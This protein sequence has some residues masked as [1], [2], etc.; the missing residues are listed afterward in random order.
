MSGNID[1]TGSIWGLCLVLIAMC[2]SVYWAIGSIVYW[3]STESNYCTGLWYIYCIKNNLK[4]GMYYCEGVVVMIMMATMIMMVMMTM[5]KAVIKLKDAPIL[6]WW[7]IQCP[8]GDWTRWF[9]IQWTIIFFVIYFIS[10]ADTIPIINR[11]I[12]ITITSILMCNALNLVGQLF[13]S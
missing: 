8:E 4:I 11:I 10:N 13:Q 12:I 1:S 2:N 7:C 3:V 9:S 6:H 5:M